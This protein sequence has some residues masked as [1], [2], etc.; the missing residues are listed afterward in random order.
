MKWRVTLHYLVS[1]FNSPL[2]FPSN[3]P[4][5][6]LCYTLPLISPSYTP[7]SLAP[8]L[9]T[10]SFTFFLPHYPFFSLTDTP[11][12]YTSLFLRPTTSTCYPSAP[13][14]TRHYAT[15][16]ITLHHI[17]PHHI[18]PNHI[19]PHH[20]TSPHTISPLGIIYIQSRKLWSQAPY[21]FQIMGRRK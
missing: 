4:L 3:S 11:Y 21:S 13:W 10:P 15:P 7:S 20:I 14:S 2:S 19:T 16:H 12:P 6:Y 8:S 17:T 1:H 9:L 5:P 18:T